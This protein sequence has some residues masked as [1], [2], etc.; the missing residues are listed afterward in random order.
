MSWLKPSPAEFWRAAD[1]YLAL[2]Y[3]GGP[4]PAAVRARLE[5][6][7][8][9]AGAESAD[10][11]AL[12]ACPAFEKAPAADEPIKFSLRLGNRA[13]PHMKLVVDRSPDGKRYLYRA[14]THDLHIRPAPG[15]PE[16]AAFAALSETNRVLAESIEAEWERLGLPTFKKLLRDDLERRKA[17]KA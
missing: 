14:D 7:R 11:A 6:L 8:T 12:F 1:A 10:P 5:S 17:A 13:Y 15:S 3:A 16:A 4:P 2:A 9:C